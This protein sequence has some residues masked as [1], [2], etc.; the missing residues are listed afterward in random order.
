[1]GMPGGK[2][3][4]ASFMFANELRMLVFGPTDVNADPKLNPT[5][6]MF[7]RG[8][9][10]TVELTGWLPITTNLVTL[11]SAVAEVGDIKAA[12]QDGW[13]IATLKNDIIPDLSG[14]FAFLSHS[15][16]SLF[17]QYKSAL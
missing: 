2:H 5:L 6:W 4:V 1:M 17:S 8:K 13:Q 10:G 16:K 7:G 3:A 14:T 12:V 9:H 15:S 11:K